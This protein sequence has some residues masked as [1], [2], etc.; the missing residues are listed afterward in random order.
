MT[1]QQI[2][3][4]NLEI[5]E[6]L[7]ALYSKYFEDHDGYIELRFKNEETKACFS[8]FYRLDDINDRSINEIR[9]LNTTC[10]VYLGVNPRPRSQAKKQ[11]D[12][13]D[14][15]C[16]WADVDANKFNN[17]KAKAYERIEAFPISPTIIID[18]G[19]GFHCYWVFE[20]PM[21]LLSTEERLEF[22]QTLSGIIEKLGGDEKKAHLDS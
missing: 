2:I 16:L 9:R 8:K 3:Q 17:D 13:Q 18:S 4:Q 22:K 5:R 14:F 19:H 10:H 6:F 12:I 7:A 15:V 20:V 11:A 21:L 1:P